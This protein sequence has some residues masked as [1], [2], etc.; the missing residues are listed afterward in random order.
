[1]RLDKLFL[2]L[3]SLIILSAYVAAQSVTIQTPVYDTAVLKDSIFT[4]TVP[5]QASGLSSD[6]TATL[7]PTTSIG[8]SCPSTSDCQKTVSQSG[9]S[10]VF[11]VR[12]DTTGIKNSPFTISASSGSTSAADVTASTAITVSE[13][14]TWSIDI[15]SSA[16]SVEDGGSVD[17]T[18]DITIT[19]GTL[20]D[21]TV[22]LTKPSGWTIS[23]GSASYSLG[24]LSSSTEST[25]T[26]TADDPSATNSFSVS[27]TGSNSAV[28]TDILAVTYAASEDNSNSSSSSSS[29]SSGVVVAGGSQSREFAVTFYGLQMGNK[30]I[31]I[32]NGNIA[33]TSLDVVFNKNIS[34]VTRLTF[35]ALNETPNLPVS[36]QGKVYSYLKV[37]QTKI[38]DK[39]IDGI[40]I[41]FKI[42]N[43]WLKANG[44]KSENM[45]LYR[46][47]DTW[48]QLQTKKLSSDAN[49]TYF[50]SISPGFSYFAVAEVSVAK[51][52]AVSIVA[53]AVSDVIN[54]ILGKED[55][56]KEEARQNIQETGASANN[57]NNL[58]G[59]VAV[60]ALIC[61]LIF[62]VYKSVK[63]K[64]KN[65]K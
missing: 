30:L 52:S 10:A 55:T 6:I 9:G 58:F 36:L 21:A 41:K 37:D 5:I 3:A 33:F 62:I 15:T 14:P 40:V 34:G 49:F 4:V 29:G 35:S 39:E 25:W 13:S 65:K 7:T 18:L 64:G 42:T 27:V 59:L 23:S 19:S 45:A 56:A 48:N 44:I 2:V 57:G 1:M 60:F 16:A 51:E 47:T 8:L 46:Y 38:T 20:E 31:T 50:E 53:D 22:T 54:K 11:T 61:A 17:L 32:S 63:E 43:A 24:D 28:K 26:V 12:A